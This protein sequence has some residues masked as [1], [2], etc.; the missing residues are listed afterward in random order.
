[1]NVGVDD[2]D[3]AR[4]REL[5]CGDLTRTLRFQSQEGR[6]LAVGLE[7]NPFEVEDDVSDVLDHS[8]NR[9][10]LVIRAFDL[11]RGNCRRRNRGKECPP[12]GIAHGRAPSVL[13]R[14]CEKPR[15]VRGVSLFFRLHLRR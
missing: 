6:L 12:Q 15:K 13:E 10:K 4:A 11:D 1:M 2:L 5:P 9:R 14:L 8:G 3:L 7:R